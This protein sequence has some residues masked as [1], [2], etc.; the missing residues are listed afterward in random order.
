[1]EAKRETCIGGG[2]TG[3]VSWLTILVGFALT[4]CRAIAVSV[5]DAGMS[6]HKVAEPAR[7]LAKTQVRTGFGFSVSLLGLPLAISR[8]SSRGERGCIMDL[9]GR[10]RSAF[11]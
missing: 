4:T 6:I 1:M 5:I 9:L 7:P 11:G 3:A 8:V 10:E 2:E